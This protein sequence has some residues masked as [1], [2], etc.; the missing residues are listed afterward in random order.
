[1]IVKGCLVKYTIYCK[2]SRFCINV[3]I[4]RIGTSGGGLVGATE[5]KDKDWEEG[6]NGD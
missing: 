2:K 4:L 3:H 6:L 5:D 1:M